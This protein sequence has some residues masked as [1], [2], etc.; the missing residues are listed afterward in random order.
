MS[1]RLL[2]FGLVLV[3]AFNIVAISTFA[4]LYFN[5]PDPPDTPGARLFERMHLDDRDFEALRESRREFLESIEP[6]RDSIMT[7]RV[8]L[9][10]EMMKDDP[11]MTTVDS[12]VGAIGEIQTAIHRKAITNM[13]E[14]GETLPRETREHML[15][16]FDRHINAQFEK[17]GRWHDDGMPPHMGRRMGEGR[18]PWM[19]DTI[20]NEDS[21][22]SR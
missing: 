5:R 11:D 14:Y 13:M 10:D 2:I 3:T 21:V 22:D 17:R 15:R 20:Q 18:R 19:R 16:M 12:L 6:Y 4:Y 8:S 1:K 9:F 7:L